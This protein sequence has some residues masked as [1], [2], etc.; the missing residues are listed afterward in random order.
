MVR[1]QDCTLTLEIT[2]QTAT[3]RR[4][5]TVSQSLELG[6]YYQAVEVE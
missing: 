3:A 6:G 4:T 1:V 5:K 2:A